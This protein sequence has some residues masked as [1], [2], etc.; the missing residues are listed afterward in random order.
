MKTMTM[1]RLRKCIEYYVRLANPCGRNNVI[2][3]KSITVFILQVNRKM[4][5]KI[6]LDLNWN[7]YQDWDEGVESYE[8]W[9]KK[10]D[11]SD[12]SFVTRN[13]R[14][15]RT[16]FLPSIANEAFHHDYVI[17]AV[18]FSGGEESWSNN[19]QFDFE[20]PVYVP[21]VFTPNNDRFQSIFR[22]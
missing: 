7:H 4:N 19:V 15:C 16:L 22:N 9:R 12:Y 14:E 2:Q 17:R 5:R 11:E 18:E 3:C 8:L 6:P 1:L 20:H 10:E 21:N 13:C